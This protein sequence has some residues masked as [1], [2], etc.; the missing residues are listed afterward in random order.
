M[1][2]HFVVLKIIVQI[3]IQG[4]HYFQHS[5]ATH[6]ILICKIKTA[7]LLA[8]ADIIHK[9][10]FALVNLISLLTDCSYGC[11]TC[12]SSIYCSVCN[13]GFVL[14]SNYCCNASTPFL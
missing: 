6:L 7:K 11:M 3:V 8:T 12:N 5:V 14:I 2:V 9:I 13:S 4:I 1:D 10:T